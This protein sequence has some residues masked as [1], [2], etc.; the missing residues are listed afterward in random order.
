MSV[1][2]DGHPP[3][4]KG[5]SFLTEPGEKVHVHVNTDSGDGMETSLVPRPI[6]SFSMLH[7]ETL[8]SWEWAW[9]GHGYI[10]YAFALAYSFA[11]YFVLHDI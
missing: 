1:L 11:V 9:G 2:R 10:S 5:I 8:K 3:A 4:L 7:V 6:P